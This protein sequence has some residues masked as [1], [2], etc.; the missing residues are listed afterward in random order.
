VLLAKAVMQLVS[1]ALSVLSEGTM[2]PPDYL[3]IPAQI[4]LGKSAKAAKITKSR[5]MSF[6][7]FE[8]KSR[9]HGQRKK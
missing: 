6:K 3:P 5:I 4:T 8:D 2:P 7:G 9:L 1:V